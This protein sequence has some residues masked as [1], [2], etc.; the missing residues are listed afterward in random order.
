MENNIRIGEKIKALRKQND[1]TQEK[2]ADYL[3]VSFQAI[4]KWECGISSP[5]IALL[6][7]LSRLFGVTIDEL[8][9]NCPDKTNQRREELQ[10]SI[11][12]TWKTG[13]L[14]KRY[15]LA[16][17]AVE[18][19][20]GDF[21]FLCELAEAEWYFSYEREDEKQAFLE[22]SI[23]HAETVIENA[24]DAE[25]KNR[26]LSTMVFALCDLGR[27]DE[28]LLFAELSE[29]ED[30]IVRCLDGE[31]KIRR[32]QEILDR[33]F[34]DLIGRL[35]SPGNPIEALDAADTIIKVM[36]P[37]GNYLYYTDEL[38]HNEIWRAGYYA[39]QGMAEE[40]MAALR[41]SLEY[42][43]QYDKIYQAGQPLPYTTPLFDRMQ[44]DPKTLLISGTSENDTYSDVANFREY[45]GWVWFDG[46]RD[47]EDFQALYNPV[48]LTE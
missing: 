46:L 38:M 1:M 47:R 20:P 10:K 9:D 23:G 30:L 39:C 32:N 2:L 42:A 8:F 3:G 28:A 41:Q 35:S 15:D 19:F 44:F 22:S 13:N 18:E 43:R 17:A 25:V 36:I 6:V 48:S 5:D 16:K 27:R 40:A 45:L 7:P 37:D 31:E 14:E 12:E 4:S 29:K 26:A 34:G 33:V 21:P 11:R 24:A